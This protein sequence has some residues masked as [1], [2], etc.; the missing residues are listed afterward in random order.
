MYEY[1]LAKMKYHSI[2]RV[3]FD[4]FKTVNVNIYIYTDSI[5][6]H[7]NFEEL[8]KVKIFLKLDVSV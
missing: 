2:I 7:T 5:Y 1:T 3:V 6:S 4:P 8:E